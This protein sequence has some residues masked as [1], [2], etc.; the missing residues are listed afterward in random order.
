MRRPMIALAA[1]L[2]FGS[3]GNAQG[4]QPT[5]VPVPG[6]AYAAPVVAYPAPPGLTADEIRDYQEDQLDRRQEMERASLELRQ[7]AERRARG[8]DDDLD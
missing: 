3:A 7:K 6:R 8:F 1:T 5:V 2:A 4:Y